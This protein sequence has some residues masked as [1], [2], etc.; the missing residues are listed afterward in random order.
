VG[1]PNGG[2]RLEFTAGFTLET[3]P[4]SV[5]SSFEQWRLIRADGVHFVVGGAGHT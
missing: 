5:A 2:F 3:F 4:A 1:Y